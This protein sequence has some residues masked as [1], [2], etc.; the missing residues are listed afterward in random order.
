MD[1]PVSSLNYVEI[2]LKNEDIWI[3]NRLL[4]KLRKAEEERKTQGNLD[5]MDFTV[6][7]DDMDGNLLLVCDTVKGKAFLIIEIDV[8]EVRLK[9]PR[10]TYRVPFE[11]FLGRPS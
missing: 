2:S 5:N 10:Y 1:R 6:G 9:T 4:E 7:V 8:A 3:L 11:W